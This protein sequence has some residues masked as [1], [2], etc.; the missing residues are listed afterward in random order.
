MST[1]AQLTRDIARRVR[2]TREGLEP[3]LT[4]EDV[5]ARLGLS[6]VGYGHYERG[7]QPFSVWHLFE[8]AT[9]LGRPV[10]YFLG[11]ST[12]LRPDEQ[13]LLGGYRRLDDSPHQARVLVTLLDL[14]QL[15][16]DAPAPTPDAEVAPLLVAQRQPDGEFRVIHGGLM[17]TNAPLDQAEL[18]PVNG[19]ALSA[20]EVLLVGLL[21]E[22]DPAEREA[23]VR[24]M[25]DR[26]SSAPA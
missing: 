21:R 18:A 16:S 5:G 26:L 10:E 20:D 25:R 7:S 23:F 2:A 4:Q 1:E 22:M 19:Q 6:K 9:I 8:L 13:V 17:E 24:E 15:W 11:L 12:E 14:C 3:R